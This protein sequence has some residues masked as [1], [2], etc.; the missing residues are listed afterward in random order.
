MACA[1][2]SGP[3]ALLLVHAGNV[4]AAYI[5][6][7]IYQLFSPFWIG[8][9]V[10]LANELVVPRMRATASAYYILAVTFIGLALGPY[11]VGQISDRLAKSGA[12]LTPGQALGAAMQWS[13]LAYAAALLF[14]WLSSRHVAKDEASRLDRA[15]AL[16]EPV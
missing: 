16:G 3:L 6:N 9:A 8:S 2:F 4:Q 5:F 12:G 10:A 7:F 14:L 1:I 15:R 11:T 13:L